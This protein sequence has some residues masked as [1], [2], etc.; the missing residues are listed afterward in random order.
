MP[1]R[2]G[3]VRFM[4]ASIGTAWLTPT[5]IEPR[6][7]ADRTGET[8]Q[9]EDILEDLFRSNARRYRLG[10]FG[11]R[12]IGKSILTS[13]VL[14]NFAQRHKERIVRVE[15]NGRSIGYRRFLKVLASGLVENAKPLLPSLGDKGQLVSKW[16]DGLA[17]FAHNDQITEGQVNTLNTKYGVGA[18]LGADLFAALRASSSFSWEESRQQ[19]AS[20]TRTQNVT[21]DLLHTALKATLQKI[22]DS[23]PWMIL[24]FFDDLDQAY[25]SDVAEM[26]P[27][28]KAI[29]DV[30]PCV[31]VVHM[32]TEML[33]DDLRREMDADFTVGPID[34]DGMLAILERRLD[35][36]S[37]EDRG[38]FRHPNVQ[39]P[40]AKLIT[41]TGN[42]HVLLR[43]I[44]GF[45]RS[46][47][48]PAEKGDDWCTD[49]A[50]LEVVKRSAV[51]PGV[52]DET[53]TRLAAI[54][55]RCL[56]RG[57]HEVQRTDLLQ[58]RLK[59]DPTRDGKTISEDEFE[60]LVRTGLLIP[61]DR[62]REESGYRMDPLLD[63]L[64]PSVAA[65]LRGS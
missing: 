19:A 3:I 9:L 25:T 17:L 38:K 49:A 16:L 60:W 53:L 31:G 47:A 18:T 39:N 1:G 37:T 27:A 21:D 56:G 40:L 44:Q 30:D 51:V 64:R 54:V 11:E 10:V 26:K 32:R 58:G 43:W 2:G 55:D 59:T 65:R 23:T 48:W 28:L 42:P 46:G 6:L 13:I 5:S 57:K 15:V 12:G 22:H 45:L 62:F 14:K 61:A 52:D 50:L 20:S 24:V 7:F 63:L 35:A 33:F 4:R 29:L 8:E 41:V 34:K 36:A